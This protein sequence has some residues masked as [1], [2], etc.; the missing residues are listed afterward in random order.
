MKLLLSLCIV[1]LLCSSVMAAN[2]AI[3]LERGV[4]NVVTSPVEIVKYTR[5][6]WIKGSEKTPHI[7]VWF[8]AGTIEGTVEMVKRGGSGLWDVVSF[9][10]AVPQNYDSLIKPDYVFEDWPRRGK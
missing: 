1:L 4:V 9:P 5:A 3:K 7:I 6:Y 10:F 8:F 2:P